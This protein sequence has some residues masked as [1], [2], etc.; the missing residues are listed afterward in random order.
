MM[1]AQRTM[2][3]EDGLRR[4]VRFGG[5]P[6]QRARRVWE[7]H[8][9]QQKLVSGSPKLLR[10]ARIRDDLLALYGDE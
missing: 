1:S 8:V 9:A 2:L 7:L 5:G 3:V 10:F 4:V 6:R